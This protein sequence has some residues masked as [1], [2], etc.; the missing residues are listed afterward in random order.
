[1]SV[2]ITRALLA[3]LIMAGL[4]IPAAA[5]TCEPPPSGLVGWWPGN[6]NANDVIAG[7]NGQLAGDATFAP[8]AV[9]LG[10]KL[11]GVGDYVQIPDSAALKPQRIS[12]EAWVR[13]DSLTTPNPT[14]GVIN[15]TQYIVFKKNTRVFNFE[16]YA[17]RKQRDNS[18]IERFAFSIGDVTGVGTL[19]IATSTT[20]VMVG[21]FYHVVGTYDGSLVRLYV[22]GVLEGQAATSVVV[23]YDT[24]PLF[25][26]TSGEAVFD[27]KLNGIIDEASIYNRALDSF[28]IAR[29]SD[30]GS[31]GKCSSATG[32][33][34]SLAT[35]IQTLNLSNGISNSLDAKLQNALDALD[36][37]NAGDVTSACNRLSAFINEVN[38][39]SG[40]ALTEAQ[41]AQ[42]AIAGAQ[43]RSALACR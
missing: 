19:A 1:M 13:F 5:Q 43:V 10:F 38:A 15:A 8:G 39:Q 11:D 16:A 35:F 2:V 17:L 37:A 21:Q 9:G 23:D 22:N 36:A 14:P 42:L 20:A 41:A 27:G 18:G 31:A 34:V 33:L 30:A 12:V 29:L 25:L 26:G 3:V 40:N 32:A 4:A 7:N 6:G 28:E 24:R